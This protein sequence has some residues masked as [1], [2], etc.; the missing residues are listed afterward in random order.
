MP[1]ENELEIAMMRFYSG[2][3]DSQGFGLIFHGQE[4]FIPQKTNQLSN[5]GCQNLEIP[6]LRRDDK[7]YLTVY[8]SKTEL[9]QAAPSPCVVCVSAHAL[10]EFIP[11]EQDIVI[12]PYGPYVQMFSATAISENCSFTKQ[13]DPML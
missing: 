7:M 9:S 6:Y 3:L 10:L 1:P 2:E 13:G 8:S 4:V 11:D 12:N 5:S